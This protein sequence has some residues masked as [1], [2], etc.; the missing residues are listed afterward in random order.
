ME[1][2]PSAVKVGAQKLTVNRQKCRLRSTLESFKVFSADLPAWHGIPAPR[3]FLHCKN[4]FPIVLKN[5]LS[6]HYTMPYNLLISENI[7]KFNKWKAETTFKTPQLILIH[8][9]G[10]IYVKRLD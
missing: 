7:A 9:E 2:V 8:R 3:E 6:R 5:T 1:L 10:N 4:H